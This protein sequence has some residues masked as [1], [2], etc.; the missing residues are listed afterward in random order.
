MARTVLKCRQGDTAYYILETST[1]N[2]ADG[3][4]KV[5]LSLCRTSQYGERKDGRVSVNRTFSEQTLA[6]QE[7]EWFKAC[8]QM[9]LAKRSRPYLRREEIRGPTGRWEGEA[10]PMRPHDQSKENSVTCHEGGK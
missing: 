9:F 7:H 8:D 5:R 1:S 4:R 6:L 10:F 3:G 2:G